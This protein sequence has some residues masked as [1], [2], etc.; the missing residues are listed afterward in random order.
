MELMATRMLGLPSDLIPSSFS[1]DG[2]VLLIGPSSDKLA[3]DLR[4]RQPISIGG[5]L[6]AGIDGPYAFLGDDKIVGVSRN[7]V[8]DSGVFSFPEGK[9][10]QAVPFG[11]TDLE[12]S[13]IH[14]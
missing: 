13:L 10:L 2:N 3:F 6:K 4:T 14:I 7:N 9:R 12:L 1:R 11:L 8:K 5:G